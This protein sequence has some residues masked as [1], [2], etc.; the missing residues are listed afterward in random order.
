MKK[1]LL[2]TLTIFWA[3]SGFSQFGSQQIISTDAFYPSNVFSADLD[4]DGDYD[5]LYSSQNGVWWHENLDGIGLFGIKHLIAQNTEES[6]S[7]V[8]ASDI[9]GDGDRDVLSTFIDGSPS[10]NGQNRVL[11]NENLDGLGNFGSQRIITLN[12]YRPTDAKTA[13]FDGDGDLDV[14]SISRGDDTIAWYENLDGLGNYGEQNV[15]ST[16]LVF[17]TVGYITDFDGDGDLDILSQSFNEGKIA[18]FKNLDGLGTFSNAIFVSINNSN[19]SVSDIIGVDIDGDNDNDIIATL[20]VEGKI[21]WFENMDGKG[22]FSDMILIAENIPKPNVINSSDIDNDGDLDL[23]SSSFINSGATSEIFYL[24]NY[25]GLGDFTNPNS[26]TNEIDYTTGLFTCDINLDGK[27]DLVS[28]SQIDSKIAWYSNNLLGISENE[29]ANYHIYPNPTNGILNIESKLPISQI[30][31]YNIL[32]QRIE[33]KR[34]TNQINLSKAE[35]G[36]YLLRME[37]ANG[38]SQTHKIVKE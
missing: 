11:W 6:A 29:F 35:A 38:N 8:S 30:S 1:K 34:N 13:D 37:D 33:I 19:Y 31:V 15:I 10:Q 7:S 9:D 24:L 22:D 27:I 28:S 26:I 4:G 36:V 2:L 12:A 18:W 21:V 3:V 25:N 20:S 14:L 23:I 17:P 16:Q 32:G 5:I